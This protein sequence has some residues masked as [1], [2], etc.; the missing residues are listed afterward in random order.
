MPSLPT[1]AAAAARGPQDR[2]AASRAM[3]SQDGKQKVL[4]SPPPA[5]GS[6]AAEDDAEADAGA[7][8]G[9][10]AEDLRAPAAKVLWSPSSEAKAADAQ[11]PR[12]ANKL[13]GG[14]KPLQRVGGGFLRLAQ[15]PSAEAAA[16]PSEASASPDAGGVKET[17]GEAAAPPPSPPLGKRK[18]SGPLS[19][20]KPKKWKRGLFGAFGG[21]PPRSDSGPSAP[22]AEAADAAPSTRNAM[23]EKIVAREPQDSKVGGWFLA[24][25]GAPRLAK[26]RHTVVLKDAAASAEGAG[27]A[28]GLAEEGTPAWAEAA[29]RALAGKGKR[30]VELPRSDDAALQ[31]RAK[32]AEEKAKA[33]AE[34]KGLGDFSFSRVKPRGKE[35][36]YA[37]YRGAR[38]VKGKAGFSFGKAPPE[39][40][41]RAPEAAEGAAE[42]AA[43]AA[44]SA[45]ALLEALREER[46]K[47]EELSEE[48][49]DSLDAEGA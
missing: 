17:K 19:F 11:A 23:V 27:G 49:C 16:A 37:R 14:R 44:V 42:G 12:A 3:E 32:A 26:F 22:A 2:G 33:K 46:A 7:G 35:P 13:S 45:E 20:P 9:D 1:R 25:G 40:A 8:A 28:E 39:D 24:I 30:P 31:K 34:A 5:S 47:A 41:E 10:G 21:A 38:G 18:R 43:A 15:R 4:W 48:I 29:L 36:A 6:E